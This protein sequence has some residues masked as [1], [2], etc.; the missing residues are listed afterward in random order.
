MFYFKNIIFYT[1]TY[2]CSGLQNI[3]FIK[4]Q[5]LNLALL[6]YWRNNTIKYKLNYFDNV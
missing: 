1:Y 2:I 3:L 5:K 6:I 4:I